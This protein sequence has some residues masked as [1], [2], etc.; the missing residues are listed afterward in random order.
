MQKA[1]TN[2]HFIMWGITYPWKGNAS[3]LSSSKEVINLGL[4][5]LGLSS[6]VFSPKGYTFSINVINMYNF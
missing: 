6:W 5:P 2:I 1:D 4:P 3:I